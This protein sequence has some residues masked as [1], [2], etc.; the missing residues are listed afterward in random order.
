M[1]E[2]AYSAIVTPFTADGAIDW[3]RMAEQIEFQIAN[4]CGL[5]KRLDAIDAATPIP[6]TAEARVAL[7]KSLTR[8]WQ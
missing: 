4:G 5:N 8:H 3:D 1:L 6:E 2:G 7:M